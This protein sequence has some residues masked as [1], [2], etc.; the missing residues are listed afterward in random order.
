[1]KRRRFSA[2]LNETVQTPQGLMHDRGG[3]FDPAYR[4]RRV[5]APMPKPLS[6][7]E[8]AERRTAAEKLE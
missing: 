4:N 2:Q 3:L 5:P 1:M 6:P 8:I 7:E